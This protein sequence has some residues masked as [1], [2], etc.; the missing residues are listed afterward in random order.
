MINNKSIFEHYQHTA[1]K[2]HK[3]IISKRIVMF[4][5]SINGTYNHQVIN[6]FDN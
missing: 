5:Q 2:N 6:I 4:T 1:H 3:K